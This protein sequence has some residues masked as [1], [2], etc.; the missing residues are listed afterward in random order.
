[1]TKQDKNKK[2]EILNGINEFRE[3]LGGE[4]HITLP[5][6]LGKKLEVSEMDEAVIRQGITYLKSLS[7]PPQKRTKKRAKK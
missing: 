2:L 1:M 3:H 4:L 5:D 6:G 7:P